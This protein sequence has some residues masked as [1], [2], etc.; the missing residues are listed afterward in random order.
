MAP[1]ILVIVYY[2]KKLWQ[3]AY[4]KKFDDFNHCCMLLALLM[5][6]NCQT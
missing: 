1:E 4:E 2:F 3:W 6:Q 5:L